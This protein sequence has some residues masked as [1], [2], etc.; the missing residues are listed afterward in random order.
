MVLFGFAANNFALK[1]ASGIV[2][3]CALPTY[4][5]NVKIISAKIFFI[6]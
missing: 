2:T 5:M 3:I 4:P 1:L 6:K